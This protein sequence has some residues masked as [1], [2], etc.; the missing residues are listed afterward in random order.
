[1]DIKPDETATCIFA[2]ATAWGPM[3]AALGEKGLKKV[4]LPHYQ[5]DDLVRML[6]WEFPRAARDEKPF[7]EF[8]RLTREYFNARPADFTAIPCQLP[9]ESMLSGKVLRACRAIPLGSTI[10]YSRLAQQIG[11][12]DASRAVATALGKNPTPLV[13]PCHRVTYAGGKLG[14]FSAPGGEQLKQRL[15]D[16]EKRI[17]NS[18]I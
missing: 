18:G 6:A 3:G 8:I 13:V 4:I 5:M 11:Q 15:L 1:M 2:W 17:V 16:L 10:S 9:D 12:P 14:G 7:E